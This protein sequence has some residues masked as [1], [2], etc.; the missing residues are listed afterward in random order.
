MAG[1]V[2]GGG[3]GLDL[4]RSLPRVSLAN[5]KPN[6]GSRKRFQASVS[7]FESQETAVSH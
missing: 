5:L 6:A 7:A 1:V 4:L 3:A 2:R